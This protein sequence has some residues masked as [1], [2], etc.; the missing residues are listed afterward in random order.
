MK[1]GYGQTQRVGK[2]VGEKGFVFVRNN[3]KKNGKN[4][5]CRMKDKYRMEKTQGNLRPRLLMVEDG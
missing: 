1:N 3:K 5:Q 2:K 4:K